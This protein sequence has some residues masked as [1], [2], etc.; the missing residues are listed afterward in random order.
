MDCGTAGNHTAHMTA[1]P[2]TSDW[3]TTRGDKWCAHLPI[4]EAMLRPVDAPLI[5][6]LQLDAPYRIAEVGCG[7]GSTALEISRQA[8]AGSV[9]H[10]FDV[11]PKLIELARSRAAPDQ[12][13]LAFEVADMSRASP[14]AAYDRLVSRFGIMFFDDP[15]AAFTNLRRWLAPRGRFAFAVWGPIEQNP[16]LT[17][18]REVVAQ[19][20]EL[21]QV[22]QDGPGA[23]RYADA[24]KLLA[25]LDRAGFA[26]L[27]VHDWV[28][29]LPVGE[30]LTPSEAARF[31]ISGF[32]TF[33][34]LLA[35]AGEDAVREAERRL[36]ARLAQH[37]RAGSVWIDG[38]VHIV[39]GSASD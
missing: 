17:T 22:D 32:S 4:M 26:Q 31:G 39:T 16:W 33:S 38:C 19:F 21:P 34:E 11:S 8:T 15:Q 23:Y 30:E 6:A 37:H 2:T 5:A 35:K 36:T 14:A 28:G 9:V 7:G 3:L 1:N 24:S 10:A 12:R 27:A 25:L 29:A 18:V 13:A 20:V